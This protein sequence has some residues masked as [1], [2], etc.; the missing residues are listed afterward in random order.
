MAKSLVQ[1]GLART[2]SD[3]PARRLMYNH[4]TGM[5]EYQYAGHQH[6]AGTAQRLL[7]WI[8]Y[9]RVDHG[10]WLLEQPGENFH[11]LNGPVAF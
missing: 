7:T 4:A 3:R 10:L 8:T 9:H 11:R 6:I 1:T 2:P 5:M